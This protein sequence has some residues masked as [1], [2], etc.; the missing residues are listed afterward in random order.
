VTGLPQ[1]DAP[2]GAVPADGAPSQAGERV[3]RPSWRAYRGFLTGV[4]VGL[5]ALSVSAAARRGA[6]GFLGVIGLTALTLVIAWRYFS[7]VRVV[8]TPTHLERVTLLGRRR[9]RPLG[10]IAEVVLVDVLSS[11]GQSSVRN[12]FVLDARGR[13]L[14]RMAGT[15]WA[16]EDITAFVDALGVP[17]IV[18][19]HATGAELRRA[20]TGTVP[21]YEAHPY[22]SAVLG[23]VGVLVAMVVGIL[24]VTA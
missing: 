18:V 17:P 16:E 8:V 5:V 1:G 7:T 24:I 11:P 23:V 6:A 22:R 10:E 3:F 2:I 15:H 14:R 9:S 13:R 21:V 12:A 20:H 4:P 19:P